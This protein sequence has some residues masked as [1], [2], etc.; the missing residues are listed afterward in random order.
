MLWI[1]KDMRLKVSYE[2]KTYEYTYIKNYEIY[3]F[4]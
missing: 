4:H 2:Y 1:D 3:I